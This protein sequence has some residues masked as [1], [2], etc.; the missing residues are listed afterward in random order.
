MQKVLKD[1]RRYRSSLVEKVILEAWR[2]VKEDDEDGS[3]DVI[4]VDSGPLYEGVY[5]A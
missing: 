1:L 4:V 5:A 2:K 3:F